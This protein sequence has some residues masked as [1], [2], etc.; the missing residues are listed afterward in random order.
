MADEAAPLL[1][2]AQLVRDADREVRSGFV[3]K[4]YGIL[5]LQMAASLLL[6]WPV[7]C[8]SEER[9][10]AHN[11]I[12]C[13]VVCLFLLSLLAM[14]GF[15][16]ALKRYPV[17]Y[18]FLS[19]LTVWMGILIGVST[20]MYTWQSVALAGGLTACMFL[21]MSAYAAVTRTD[22]TGAGE[23]V[24][25][26]VMCLMLFG[27]TISIMLFVG[28]RP[29]R[30]LMLYDFCGV[31]LFAFCVVYDTQLIM[32]GGAKLQLGIDDYCAASLTLYVD[33]ANSFLHI[34]RLVGQRGG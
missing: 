2:S 9:I 20:A 12:L 27:A 26:G 11:W 18:A 33:L 22:F 13:A 10:E 3:R 31:L 14:T 16:G 8:L 15:E 5:F 29:D 24:R 4:V 19:M 32:G 21:A 30:S 25:V 28:V 1:P 6:A 17:N 7:R 34:L 23:Y